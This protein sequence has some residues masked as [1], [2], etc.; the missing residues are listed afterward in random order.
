MT[1]A[2]LTLGTVLGALLWAAVLA[3]VTG[4]E[5]DRA[6]AVGG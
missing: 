5:A 1:A 3:L 4:F 6:G 2:E